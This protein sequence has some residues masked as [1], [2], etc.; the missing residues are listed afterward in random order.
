MSPASPR[1][2]PALLLG[3]LALVALGFLNSLEN[4]ARERITT[5]RRGDLLRDLTA[6]LPP[7]R[8][9][10]DPLADRIELIGALP[11]RLPVIV[12]RARR[13]GQ[14]VAALLETMAPQGYG[15]PI[16]LLVAIAPDGRLIGVRTL[17]HRETP[18]LGDAI[19]SAKSG[20]IEAFAGRSL[21]DP[22]PSRWA[23]RR[24]GGEFDQFA[25][26]T[27]TPRAVVGAIH[28]S[29]LLFRDLGER[30]YTAPSGSVI[31]VSR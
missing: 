9:D 23:V 7:A 4:L 6:L 13:A 8:F 2:H 17:E 15:G 21:T 20:W 31:E 19:E 27:V 26:A 29:L 11:G 22:P 14:P 1:L 10:N 30:L 5:N 25:G 12:R 3:G 18:G 16:R 24:D 28:G